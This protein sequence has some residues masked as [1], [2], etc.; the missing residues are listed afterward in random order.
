MTAVEINAMSLEE[1][2]AKTFEIIQNNTEAK[3]W[4]AK[5]STLVST[6]GFTPDNF[7]GMFL[8]KWTN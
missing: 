8:A 7:Y 2:A 3:Q 4:F 6:G 5:Y 1:K